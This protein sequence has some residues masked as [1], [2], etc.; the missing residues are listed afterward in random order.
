[1]RFELT[2]FASLLEASAIPFPKRGQQYKNATLQLRHGS[3]TSIVSQYSGPKNLYTYATFFNLFWHRQ[4]VVDLNTLN[5]SRITLDSCSTHD[6]RLRIVSQ[7][8]CAEFK[9]ACLVLL[10]NVHRLPT[11]EQIAWLSLLFMNFIREYM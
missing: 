10:C 5:Y 4:R 8:H 9:P 1:M 2:T 6:H 3:L 11:N 7:V